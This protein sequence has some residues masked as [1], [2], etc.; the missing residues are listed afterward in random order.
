MGDAWTTTIRLSSN[1][2]GHLRR[3]VLRHALR[4]KAD[5]VSV[6]VTYHD[7]TEQVQQ[8]A[9]YRLW[10]NGWLQPGG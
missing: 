9:P 3:G 2:T 8:Y 6:I 5:V 4:S 1:F 7:S 10:V